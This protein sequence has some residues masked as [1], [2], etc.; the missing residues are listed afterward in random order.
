MVSTAST[1]PGLTRLPI[2]ELDIV[3][4]VATGPCECLANAHLFSAFA[5]E[6]LH[7]NRA[8]EI[9]RKDPL[10]F[11]FR[12]PHAP[13]NW[14]AVSQA[15]SCAQILASLLPASIIVGSCSVMDLF[16]LTAGAASI[17][18]L[19]AAVYFYFRQRQAEQVA[20]GFYSAIQNQVIEL[21]DQLTKATSIRSDAYFEVLRTK[22]ESAL[23]AANVLKKNLDAYHD[24]LWPR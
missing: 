8:A 23:S 5:R 13:M 20:K 3:V 17:V 16:N 19:V 2:Q 10:A 14:A 15:F 6:S 9:A 21:Q 1:P 7:G 4:S 18:G 24:T 22:V 12:A 11:V